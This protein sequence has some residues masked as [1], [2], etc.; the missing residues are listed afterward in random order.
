MI[1][2]SIS[3]ADVIA[4]TRGAILLGRDRRRERTRA[5][6]PWTAFVT[7]PRG[8]SSFFS[9]AVSISS[10]SAFAT[11]LRAFATSI[12]FSFTPDADAASEVSAATNSASVAPS[13]GISPLA[14]RSETH[15]LDLPNNPATSL[16]VGR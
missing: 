12:G 3:T 14:R 8:S 4:K 11:A 7:C 6:A 13:S 1:A 10:R 2:S 15:R 9:S 5:K 16:N